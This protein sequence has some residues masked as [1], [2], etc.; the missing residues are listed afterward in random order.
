MASLQ[1][2]AKQLVAPPKG[3]LA[4]DE[5][6]GTIGK[7]FDKIGVENTEEN[8]RAYRELLF[9]TKGF[10]QYISGVIMYDET[11][12]QR[13]S[14][15]HTF[16]TAL[17]REGVLTGIKV[18]QGLE[19]W[20]GSPV[21]KVT[22]GLDGL[23][24]RL[25]EYA[26]FDAAFAKWRAVYTI[27]ETTPTQSCIDEN[28][29]RLAVYAKLCQ[30]AGIVPIVEP[31]VLMDAEGSSHSIERCY[32]VT[33]SVLAAVFAEIKKQN[34][35]LSAMLLKPNMVIPGKDFGS[36]ATPEQVAEMTIK[37]LKETVPAE[38]P[39]IVFL[40]GGQSDEEAC[41]NL[42]AMHV[43]GEQLPWELSFSY[44]RGLQSAALKAWVGKSE[45]VP[46]AQE[47]FLRSAMLTSAARMGK[48][49]EAYVH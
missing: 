37:C 49:S 5:S 7:R 3:I 12:R 41:A 35:E 22:K 30:E 40:S 42:N 32:E 44:G 2:I 34:V 21:E 48:Y 28:A 24:E 26:A 10:G 15:G 9:A 45:N 1:S 27:S 25:K 11:I 14:D 16:V 38:V 31:E 46:A 19:E 17:E 47:A 39:G 23:A 29:K 33:K 20:N 43:R 8:R 6:T 4:A 36:K 13:A 18:D